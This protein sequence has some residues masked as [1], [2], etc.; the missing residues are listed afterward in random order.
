L[1][2]H[3]R[4]AAPHLG[5]VMQ[6][7]FLSVFAGLLVLVS[8]YA[9]AEG[10]KP[11][12]DA[13]Y[14]AL[15]SDARQGNNKF[16]QLNAR[17][18]SA[19]LNQKNFKSDALH[20]SFDDKLG[21]ST[22][23]WAPNAAQASST[24]KLLTFSPLRPELRTETVAR[25]V[26]AQ[27]ASYLRLDRNG[28]K[29]AK[30][31][32]THD[33][34]R[35]PIIAR[36]KQ[37]K[38]GLEVFGRTLNVMMD[39]NLNAVATSGYFAPAE[40]ATGNSQLRASNDA[41]ATLGAES[42][43][44]SAFADMGGS[45]TSA[46]FGAL[47]NA[48]DYTVYSVRSS[49]DD[50]HIVGTPQ[51][52]K[53]YYYLDGSYIPAWY[54]SVHAQTVDAATDD[55]YGY[56]VSAVDGKVLFRKNLT[57]DDAYSYRV[58]ADSTTPFR[59]NDEP[60]NGNTLDPYT[61]GVNGNQGRTQNVANLVNL[62]NSGLI[63]NAAA[64]LDPWLAPGASVTTGNNV[65]AYMNLAGGDGFDA[66]D[67]RGATSSAGAFDYPYTTD[68]DPATASQRQAAITNQFFVNNWLHD[69]W[70]DH[71]FNEAAGN[72]QLSNYGRGG[73]AGDPIMA[74]GQDNSGRNNA[75]MSTPPDGASPIQRMLLFDG[76]RLASST[77][78][79]TQ[80]AGIGS[81]AFGTAS[82][83]PRSFDLTANIVRIADAANATDG[84][85]PAANAAA[86]AGK[87][88]L[89]DRGVC[90]FKTKTRNAQNA[91]AAAVLIANNRAGG[92]P[93]LGNDA[94]ITT[95]ITIPTMSI[96]QADGNTVKAA[97][98]GTVTA[99]M[100]L[101]FA[102]DRD[103][104]MDI[105]IIAHEFFHY[106]SNRLI[107][108]ALGLSNQQGGG[109][110]E[111]WSDFDAML[112]TVRPEDALVAG[113]NKYQGAYPL[114]GYVI[115]NQYFGI[116]RYPYSTDMSVD[117]LSFKHISNGVPLPTTAPVAPGFGLTGADNAEVHNTGEIWCTAL[118]EVYASLLNDPRYTAL[119]AR[120]RMQDYI[121]AGLKMTPVSP[122]MLE[123]RD[124]LLASARATDAGDFTL[125]AS[126][127][128]KRGMGVG[129]RAPDRGSSTNAGALESSVAIAAGVEVTGAA[130]D[131]SGLPATV[132][133]D[134]DSDG[135]LDIGETGRLSF[136]VVNHGTA[137]MTQTLTGTIT[138]VPGVSFSN[139]G[140]LVV[141]TLLIGQTAVISVLVTL[142]S[143]TQAQPLSLALKFP[144]ANDPR[145][146][147]VGAGGISAQGGQFDTVVNYDEMP[148][149][150]S[151]DVEDTLAN[152]HDWKRDNGGTIGPGWKLISGTDLF[153]AD[154]FGSGQF[155][156]GPDN[157]HPSDIS[158]ASPAISVGSVS[159]FT[160]AFD[161]F[162]AFEFAGTDPSGTAFGFDG[163]VIEVSQDGGLTWA[164]A[165]D[166]AIGG[167]VVAGTG[168]NGFVL[169]LKPDG[170]F[171]PT[172]STNG[173]RGFV[174]ANKD[175]NNPA[176]E[177]VVI[178]FAKKLAG[179]TVR[180]RFRETSD[181]A[182]AVL[183]WVV[184][185]IAVTGAGNKPF[186][187]TVADSGAGNRVP[188]ANAGPNLTGFTRDTVQL[189]GGGSSDPYNTALT[190]QWLQTG[191]PAVTLDNAT[192][193]TPSFVV[194]D[195]IGTLSFS[196]TVTDAV[197]R[198]S[199]P[200]TVAV[201]TSKAP[202][203]GGAMGAELLLMGL[204]AAALRRRR[205][206]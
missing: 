96:S 201:V 198:S 10:A 190:Y 53:V 143:A 79:I 47:R 158:L 103:G 195:E 39:R 83:G 193:K 7:V 69:F 9:A 40:I 49:G 68:A 99:H 173:R 107:G 123:A 203:K 199:T 37:Y 196:L 145:T 184:D 58:F 188:I 54:A 46:S 165:F 133:G 170:T 100:A 126:A 4:R 33:I 102:P 137:D 56:V 22:F 44:T 85:Q 177:H 192:S 35:G 118:W 130:L 206:R 78:T 48:G 81:L 151:D 161:H 105:Q 84:C 194:P 168:Y 90:T 59:P 76:P 74:Q 122:T 43:L 62:V 189:N 98:A 121:I 64:K 21:T 167:S 25:E 66:G 141:P 135:V 132:V 15:A 142:N 97:L 23:L 129:A 113:N 109:M 191:G 185:N 26:L 181:A 106:V 95:T 127:F 28:I 139:G 114:S 5:E 71:G 197:G 19:L 50:Y 175:P 116:R 111:G 110:G 87:I 93:G 112:L 42:A 124:A 136:T 178:S 159:D 179:K 166:A 101:L 147:S 164:D 134:A 117:P 152:L 38:N 186:S 104:T 29:D 8:G 148:F 3:L 176:L 16:A 61:G 169:S 180:I 125:M 55:Y 32:E 60:I 52:K 162:Y 45:A 41:S 183:G 2:R 1:L 63:V 82:F 88:A 172:D 174:N 119:Q 156:F 138:P 75:N 144:A 92:P 14:S 57:N 31:F 18:H 11:N 30:L 86:L 120:S 24:A 77:L 12:Y 89:I 163:G 73:V 34:G 171:D 80:P 146:G 6:K 187:K 51:A 72:A 200:A 157:D 153:G 182:A 91:G 67:V 13:S 65:D 36:F 202:H 17:L 128:A 27:Q 131:F 150:T 205:K 108:N 140:A 70:Y 204:A 94:T 149:A 160:L 155:W 154:V 20:S 115:D